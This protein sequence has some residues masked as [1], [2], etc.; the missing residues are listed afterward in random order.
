[1]YQ[2]KEFFEYIFN[3]VKIWIIIQPWQQGLRVRNGKDV[4]LLNGGIYFKLPY[5]DSVY[6]QETRL[7]V[8]SLPIQTLTSKD[9]KTVTLSGSIGYS[10][11]NIE[12]LYK[13]LYHPETTIS[14]MAMSE[15]SNFIFNNDLKNIDPAR[16]E[17]AVLSKLNAEDY[18][19][20]FEYFQI[21]SFAVVRTLR[22]IQDQSWISEGMDMDKKK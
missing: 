22:L 3:A 2:V 10:I 6:V 9:L 21:T 5:F 1:M 19:L 8:V 17:K 11:T 18:G 20:K 14:N 13:T 12:T 7:R 16:I 4:K 15:M